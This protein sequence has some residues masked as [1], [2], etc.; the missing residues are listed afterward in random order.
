MRFTASFC[1]LLVTA[2]STASGQ[3]IYLDQGWDS[4]YREE[5]Y[6]TAQGSQL[7]PFKWFL[8]LEQ[9]NVNKPFRDA[10][11][12][13]KY[14]FLPAAPTARNP[15][16]L[17]IG[18]VLDGVD[19]VASKMAGLEPKQ[20][21]VIQAA[22]RYA[23][24]KAYLGAS[25]DQELYP[26]EQ[27][28]WFG[29]TCA[30]CHTHEIEFGGKTL[31]I[32][33]GSA[34]ADL[35]SFLRDLGI[36]LDN[37]WE[38]SEKLKRFAVRVGRGSGS[39]DAF[40]NEVKQM[41]DAL[42][43]LVARN[44]AKHPYGHSRL[45]AFGAIL[46]AV[47][48]TALNEPANR[49]ESNAPVSYPS[50]WNTPQMGYVQWNASAD[51]AEG[52]NVG[53]VLGVFGSYTLEPGRTQFDSTVRLR[54]LVRLEHGLLETLSAPDW[55]EEIL[56]KLDREQVDAGKVLFAKNCV[57]CHGIR[58]ASG[59]FDL[60]SAGKIPIRS[61]TLQEVGTDPQFLINLVAEN[62]AQTG[63]LKPLLGNV[64]QVPR[65]TMLTAVVGA[66]IQNRAIAEGVEL[67]QPLPQDPPH[68]AGVGTGYIS[69]PLEGIWASAPYFHNGSVPSLYE[70]LLPAAQRSKSFWVGARKFDPVKVGFVTEQSGFGSRFNVEDKE[71]GA[72]PGNSNAGHEGHGANQ[73]EGFT[74]TFEDGDWRDF[75]EAERYALVEYM[76]SLSSK[77]TLKPVSIS[78][79]EA[80][81]ISKELDVL[82]DDAAEPT[83]KQ[84]ELIP[85]DEAE[86]ISNIVDLTTKRMEMQ[87]ANKERV[88][89]AVH[90]KDHGCVTAKF[91]VNPALP[92]EHAVGVF[93]PGAT[94]D[95]FIRFSNASVEVLPD[96]FRDP[97]GKVRHGS[98]GMAI[99]LLGVKGESLLPLHGALTQDFVMVN[100][101]S[102]AFANVED[103]EL[104]S[105]VLIDHFGQPNPA[106][107]FFIQRLGPNSTSTPEQR[108]RAKKTRQ[109]VQRISADAVDGDKGAF[110]QPPASAADNP[111]YSAAPFLF[112]DGR[113]MKFRAAPVAR[114][115]DPPKV[116]DPDYL[117]NA[118]IKRLASEAVVF[119][120]AIQVRSADQLDLATDIEN[121]S[122]EWDD[123]YVS[124]ARITIPPQ[125]F[126]SPQQR[127]KCE[128][129]FFTPWHGTAE[130][131]PLGGIN[132]L[133]KA[134]YL[135]SARHRSL[136][137]EPPSSND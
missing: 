137:K 90:P 95:A 76:K 43:R 4:E 28:A 101:P 88:L 64:D 126:N 119:D 65:T 10:D 134:V 69:R 109:I 122:T 107:H 123:D 37:T 125:K 15:H 16:G 35:E 79:D 117:R 132:R 83:S 25:F 81:R 6:F 46:N 80:A 9:V 20:R 77:P 55:P 8:E 75:T 133:R 17:P 22:T 12:I 60:N 52:R 82:A 105:Q 44:K 50:L 108:E 11:N 3:T 131:R 1:L 98:R 91:E 124:V 121:A 32:D 112:G 24:K 29:L 94:Y 38:D 27:E 93:Q 84:L 58:N 127:E 19:P 115:L 54:N 114:S 21:M 74:Q 120:F 63:A 56:G 106:Q 102:F 100:Q 118:L 31:R 34:Q 99:K 41:A 128:Q 78:D 40:R 18:F 85:D 39:L 97:T 49:R 104:L 89:R 103:Y 47:C 135:A 92:A 73:T 48:E 30:A 71:G 26:K 67:Q 53:E 62:T 51:F 33:G 130:H 23:I 110:F 70:T 113:V 96:S 87:Y 36:A 129:L 45:D 42:N 72:I 116:D 57:S 136:P 59:Q 5:F 7:I 61:S 13:R 86:R 68:P 111:Y 14:G 66:I 2:A